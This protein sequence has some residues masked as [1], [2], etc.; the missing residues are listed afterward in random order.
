MGSFRHAAGLAIHCK[1]WIKGH[2]QYL[3]GNLIYREKNIVKGYTD[4]DHLLAAAHWLETAQDATP[5]GGV[6]GRYRLNVGWTSS[7]PET[8]GYIIPTFL[9]LASHLKDDRFRERARRAVDFLLS[10]QLESG[11]FPGLEIAENRADPSPFNTAQI[12]NGLITWA[13]ATSDPKVALA[14]RRAGD[15]LISIQD[16][17]GAWRK[18]YYYGVAPTYAA[19]MACWLA[20][21]GQ[22]TGERKYLDAASRNID[23]VLSHRVPQSD[24]IENMGFDAES[25]KKRTA[26]LRDSQSPGRHRRRC[27]SG[28]QDC[29]EA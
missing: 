2:S 13:E 3:L 22:Y 4:A 8:T 9:E 23:W 5:D 1:F 7:Y 14:A 17:D 10:I 26:Y 29:Q 24:W 19:H 21:L 16:S 11:A 12:I 15:W 20:Q 27:C 25:H 28:D 18:H 6:V